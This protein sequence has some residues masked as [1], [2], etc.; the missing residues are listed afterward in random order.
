M[1]IETTSSILNLLGIQII[2]SYLRLLPLSISFLI[3]L[4]VGLQKSS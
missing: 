1:G 2:W 4:L 3:F